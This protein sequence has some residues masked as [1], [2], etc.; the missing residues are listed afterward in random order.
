MKTKER[1]SGIKKRVTTKHRERLRKGVL[2]WAG[3]EKLTKTIIIYYSHN[4]ET[5]RRVTKNEGLPQLPERACIS[6]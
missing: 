2:V 5:K 4:Y 3:K 1:G 6:S